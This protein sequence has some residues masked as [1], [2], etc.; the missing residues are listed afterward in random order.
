VSE[1]LPAI[2]VIPEIGGVNEH[3]EAV[4]RR[5][6]A[7]GYA[8]LAPDLFSING[9]RPA[10]FFQERLVK[11]LGFVRKLPPIAWRDTEFRNVELAKLPD[12]DCSEIGGPAIKCFQA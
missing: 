3:I 5:L 8:V 11:A 4:A 10:T 12:P 9:K 2:I 6:A 1:P 7:A